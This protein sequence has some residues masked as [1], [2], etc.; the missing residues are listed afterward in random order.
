MIKQHWSVTIQ[1]P[2]EKVWKTMLEQDTYRIWTAEFMPGCYYE[3]SWE[4]GSKIKFLG[5]D[6]SGGMTS[7]IAA[8][9]PNEFVSIR[10]LGY[11][12]DG[13]EDTESDEIKAWAPA[14]ENYTF[15]EQDGFTRVDVDL[16]T[17][18]EMAEMMDTMWIKALAKL[19]EICES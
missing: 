8:N 10:H 17:E 15:T 3:G 9:I 5:P 12:K 6:G 11:I 13:V 16:D 4:T 19:K 1:A 7:E 18:D 14:Y 2:K